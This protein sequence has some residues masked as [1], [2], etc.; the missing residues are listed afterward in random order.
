MY[1]IFQ[2]YLS[3]ASALFRVTGTSWWSWLIECQGW[4]PLGL[5]SLFTVAM[6]SLIGLLAIWGALGRGNWFLRVAVLRGCISLL[7]VIPAF[8][9]VIVY[10]IQAGLTIVV[11]AA[12]RN[13]QLSR[14]AATA[15]DGSEAP[16]SPVAPWQF[17]IRD[18]L[19]LTVLVACIS[20]MLTGAPTAV[21]VQWRAL[22]AEGL[23]AA[24]ATIAA[25]WIALGNGRRLAR[26]ASLFLLLPAAL[27]VLWLALWRWSRPRRSVSSSIARR[28]GVSR[29]ALVVASLLILLP[30]GSLYWRLANPRP[31]PKI[32]VPDPN[33]YEELVRTAKLIGSV[34][35]PDFNTATPA[36]VKAYVAQCAGVYMPVHA[37][38]AKP[39]QTPTPSVDKDM[40]E[41]WAEIDSLVKMA[42]AL[43]AL[44]K[45]AA[46]E[47][48]KAAAIAAY[49]DNI[50]VGQAL[51]Q[52]GVCADLLAGL[53]L[54]GMGIRGI[55][56]LRTTL[57][58]GQCRAALP[59]LRELFNKPLPL[60]ECLARDDAWTD[61][62][63]GWQGRLRA[64][65]S[66]M[67]GERDSRLQM[68]TL[69]CNRAHAE[70]RLLIYRFAIRAYSLEHGRNPGRLADLVPDYLPEPL[71]DPFSG[72]PFVYRLTSTG[73]ELRSAEIDRDRRKPAAFSDDPK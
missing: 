5:L 8:E 43:Y 60:E 32:A 30:T 71:K 40:A 42:D 25:V 6:M 59:T 57:S 47:G 34:K 58:A 44:G 66:E 56:D 36:Q 53:I 15:P 33:G 1:S 4:R 65:I 18:L 73:Y 67:T 37:A 55:A 48:R 39:C 61:R 9:L 35:S 68:T 26:L 63:G 17:S 41:V 21:W 24:A 51:Q 28:V 29:A 14:L 50:R 45:V 27:M 2:T 69:L 54:E 23:I 52:G 64:M 7:L 38:L 12:W 10:L 22:L 16:P 19:L 46:T 49:L 20:A 11:L 31:M 70:R 62:T 13:W 3:E 72:G